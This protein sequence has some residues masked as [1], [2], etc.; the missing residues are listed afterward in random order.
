ME[1][2]VNVDP[3]QINEMVPKAILESAIGE[4]LTEAVQR[5]VKKLSMSFDNPL[6]PVVAAE[7]RIIMLAILRDE[8]AEQIRELV[9]QKL[10]EDFTS[11]ILEK[12]WDAFERD[13]G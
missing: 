5:E 3:K 8:Y 2:E 11:R 4:R 7:M 10:S 12:A 6:Q 9:R 1:I 13:I